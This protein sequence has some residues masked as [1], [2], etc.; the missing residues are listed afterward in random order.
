[1]NRQSGLVIGLAA[2][3]TVL[4]VDGRGATPDTGGWKSGAASV[5][6]TP[7][8]PLWMAGYA[9]R[10]RPAEGKETD[11]YAKA[12]A[13]ED[14]RGKRLVI[15]TLDLIGVPR[16]LRTDLEKRV[17]E[18]HGLPP[19]GL[20]LNASHTHSGPE[21]RLGHIPPVDGNP[22]LA[23]ESEAYGDHLKDQLFKLIGEAIGRLGPARLGYTHARAGFAM[24]RRLPTPSGYQNSP[25]PDGPVDQSVPVLRVEDEKGKLQAVMFGYACHN[26]TLSLYTWN[27]DYAGYAQEYVQASHPG[28]IALFLMGCGGDQ[29]P[30]P[31]RTVELA[32]QHGRALANAVETALSV[33]PRPV[34]GPL[35]AVYGEVALDYDS[36]PTRE[37]FQ[38]R[39]GSKDKL[40]ASHA[41]RF[42]DRLDAGE[43]LPTSYPCPVHVVRFGDDLLLTALGGE[44]CVDYSIRLK[45]ELAGKAVVWVA[46]YSNDV[47]GYVPS[48]RVREEGGYEALD[49]MRYSRTHPAPWAPTLE[50]KIIGKVHELVRGLGQ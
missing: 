21:L 32:E 44:T 19:E 45:R 37:L 27:A 40:E 1:M 20:L 17:E 18:A 13:I 31:R 47:M 22:R 5:R 34:N 8:A 38:Q 33:A 49:A 2:C 25:Y 16:A 11:L 48:R 26:T 12:L 35:R 23:R 14:A 30:Y 46:G 42:L 43:A 36:V 9:S 15:V 4:A 39:L 50:E 7:E 10:N 41:K 6:I 24:N 3:L 29:N 28:T